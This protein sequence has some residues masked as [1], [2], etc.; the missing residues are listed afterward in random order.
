M[1]HLSVAS[2]KSFVYNKFTSKCIKI[3]LKSLELSNKYKTKTTTIIATKSFSSSSYTCSLQHPCYKK[4]HLYHSTRQ[5]LNDVIADDDYL[6]IR[7]YLRIK[8]WLHS[9]PYDDEQAKDLYCII[10]WF[11][12]IRIISTLQQISPRIVFVV[13]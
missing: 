7:K 9:Y 4:S 1:L 6:T 8:L 10:V 5:M 12:I 11:L 13:P 2:C 3:S